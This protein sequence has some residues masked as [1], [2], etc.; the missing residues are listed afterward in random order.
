MHYLSKAELDQLAD[1]SNLKIFDT[2]KDAV[3]L[4][5]GANKI[6]QTLWKLCLI[7]SLIFIAAE[8]LLI[9]FFNNTKRT[10]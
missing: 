8:I 1:K 5:A 9:R 4:I 10:I 3:K 6:G 7:L 2:D